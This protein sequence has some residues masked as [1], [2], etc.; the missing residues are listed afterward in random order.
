MKALSLTQPWA[1][2]VASGAKSIET[3]S[4]YTPY[5][6]PLAIQAAKSF[7]RDCRELCLEAPFR[8]AIVAAGIHFIAHLPLGMML[9]TCELVD[10]VRTEMIRDSIDETERAFGDY[11]NRRYA[12]VLRNIKPLAVCEPV[13]GALGLWEW[14]R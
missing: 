1:T 2:L 9:A 14:P 7:P 6:G 5:R 8:N 11:S 13:K 10:C 4:W 3:R 12:F